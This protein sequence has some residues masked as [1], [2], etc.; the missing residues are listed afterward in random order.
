MRTDQHL[1]SQIFQASSDEMRNNSRG[2]MG[3]LP[4]SFSCS[5]CGLGFRVAPEHV[6]VIRKALVA[7]C[8]ATSCAKELPNMA[9]VDI[10]QRP[11]W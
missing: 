1:G 7:F 11:K 4:V 8:S 2:S 6:A 3:S 5:S 10:P 9:I